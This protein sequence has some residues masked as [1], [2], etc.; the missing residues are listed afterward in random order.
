MEWFIWLMFGHFFS[1]FMFQNNTMALNKKSRDFKGFQSCFSHCYL[2][3]FIVCL[4]ICLGGGIQ[5]SFYLF[6]GIFL[7][8][9]FIDRYNLI[10]MW[11]S[12]YNIR[13]WDTVLNEGKKLTDNVTIRD[14]IMISFGS[15]VYV[16]IDQTIHIFLMFLFISM[17]IL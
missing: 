10:S 14:A 8:H 4:F 7:S 6:C 3:S 1:D 2:Y 9:W 17:C 12:F 15:F 11:C 16:I 13:S 5:L